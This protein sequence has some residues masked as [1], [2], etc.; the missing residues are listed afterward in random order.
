MKKLIITA[1][2]IAAFTLISCAGKSKA[3]PAKTEQSTA[4]SMADRIMK[5]A[6][7][8]ETVIK[9]AESAQPE[10]TAPLYELAAKHGFKLGT[11][12]NPQQLQKK[13]YTDMVKESE[14]QPEK[15]K[16]N[17]CNELLQC[18]QNCRVC[19]D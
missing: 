16:R 14:R 3:T 11:V 12:I 8:T 15:R 1:I 4:P 10:I 6:E 19:S 5:S 18:R 13:A 17:A 2:A 7:K 9:P